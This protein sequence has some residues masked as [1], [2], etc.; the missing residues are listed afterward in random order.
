MVLGTRPYFGTGVN[1]GLTD[2]SRLRARARLADDLGYDLLS[3]M[4]HPY[5]ENRPEAY[6]ALAVM[7]GET[8]R[9]SGY[10]GVTN[11]PL[12]P[13]PLL[14][15]ALSTLSAFTGGRVVLGLG[16]G[17]FWDE[18]TKLGV[19][20]LRPIQAVR[21]FEEAIEL[22][23]ALSG[24][25][26]EP[27]TFDGTYYQVHGV[28]PAP[29]PDAP[30]WTGSSG[31]TALQI[32]GRLADGWIPSRAADWTSEHY[33]WA[34]PL[35]DRAAVDAGRDPS[36]VLTYFNLPGTLT[37]EPLRHPRSE[38]GRWVGGSPEQWV[39][40]LTRAVLQTTPPGS[41]SY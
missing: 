8:H 14:A 31:R 28:Y 15:R 30:I 5:A 13:A 20:P 7:L 22:V 29:V 27:V 1:G 18:I 24:G 19:S 21:A 6:T 9:I 16:S 38:D 25:G 12:R 37:A 41:T 36:D 40:E 39:D 3:I 2:A 23:R 35:I 26:R 11:L 32:T 17:G 33:Q 10:V 4:D 34:R